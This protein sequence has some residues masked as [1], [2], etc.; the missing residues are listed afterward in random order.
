MNYWFWRIYVFIQIVP[1][2]LKCFKSYKV[3]KRDPF[4]IGVICVLPP[5][6]GEEPLKTPDCA[7]WI[8]FV[9]SEFSHDGKIW[10][11]VPSHLLSNQKAWVRSLFGS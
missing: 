5:L 7:T 2:L 8:N 1:C 9:Y 4:P 3:S 11:I 10:S 6:L